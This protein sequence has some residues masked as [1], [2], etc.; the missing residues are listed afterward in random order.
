M[1]LLG[2]F[3]VFAAGAL[4]HDVPFLRFM[5]AMLLMLIGSVF[6]TVN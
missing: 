5:S 1:E 4:L 6:I 3:M 2:Y